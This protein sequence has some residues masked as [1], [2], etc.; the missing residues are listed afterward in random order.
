MFGSITRIQLCLAMCL[1]AVSFLGC[2]SQTCIKYQN[3]AGVAMI[4]YVGYGDSRHIDSVAMIVNDSITGCG[5][6]RMVGSKTHHVKFPVNARI[7]IFAQGDLWEEL[8]FKMDK[9]T[10]L[11]VY[12]RIECQSLS[13]SPLD[14]HNAVENAK[15]QNRL[16]DSSLTDNYCWL[17]EKMDD[18]YDYERCTELS[19]DGKRELCD[20]L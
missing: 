9:N 8:F 3:V 20:L 7:Q 2:P 4:G 11:K 1:M 10:I 14:F 17:L 19:V 13:T 18:S 12:N 5:I 6:P 15:K 16:I